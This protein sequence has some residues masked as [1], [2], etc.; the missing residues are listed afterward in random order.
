MTP[1]RRLRP[2]LP[3]AATSA[4]VLAWS[5][6]VVPAL[7][8]GPAVR[9]A[10]NVAASAVLVV[11][12]RRGGLT[13]AEM[14]ISRRTA[15]SGTLWG[16]A[17][18]AVAVVG[19]G[20]ALAIPPLRDVLAAAAPGESA[21]TVLL[22]VTVLIPIGTVLCE[23]LAFRGVLLALALR[24]FSPRIAVAVVSAVFGLWHVAS[25]QAPG[26]T[27]GPSAVAGVVLATAV[28]GLVLGWLRHRSGSLLAPVGLHLGTNSVGLAATLAASRL[29][30]G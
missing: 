4:A 7:P 24:A 8:P 28:G 18:L 27:T 22:R 14:G 17:A 26:G 13:W 5:N 10:A 20:A 21:G 29:V 9:A 16:G 1:F 12:A 30:A 25:A 2:W 23:E 11:A 15:A 6:G 3:L 19:Y